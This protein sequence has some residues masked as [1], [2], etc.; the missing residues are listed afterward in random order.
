MAFVGPNGKELIESPDVTILTLGGAS[1]PKLGSDGTWAGIL[2]KEKVEISPLRPAN[3]G[4]AVQWSDIFRQRFVGQPLKRIAL[5]AGI[6]RFVVSVRED[7]GAVL[8][9]ILI[10]KSVGIVC[11]VH[12]ETLLGADFANCRDARRNVVMHVA[13]AVPRVDQ[14]LGLPLQDHAIAEGEVAEYIWRPAGEI[15]A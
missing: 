1:W 14:D 6:E 10:R 13:F 4:F 7:E 12:L 3:C 15:H 8:L 5:C 11:R 9:Q 2:E